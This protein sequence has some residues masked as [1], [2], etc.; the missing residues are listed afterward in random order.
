[1]KVLICL[2]G[3][4][5]VGCGSA[6][7]RNGRISTGLGCYAAAAVVSGLGGGI[8][9]GTANYPTSQELARDPY[10]QIGPTSGGYAA[11]VIGSIVGAGLA[12]TGTYYLISDVPVDYNKQVRKY[13]QQQR[14]QREL[15]QQLEKMEQKMPGGGQ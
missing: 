12:L 11:L 3:L 1:M 6:Y 13:K 7:T 2:L 14:R 10:Q 5:F 15:K 9:A 8:Y 4:L